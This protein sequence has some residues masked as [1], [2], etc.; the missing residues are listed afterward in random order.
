MQ[1]LKI[2]P[3]YTVEEVATIIQT[4]TNY[5]Y[6]LFKSNLLIPLKL[7]RFKVRHEELMLFLEKWQGYDLTDPF[8]I[9]N[10]KGD[11]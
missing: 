3:L 1:E 11:N 6:S 4:N 8:N 10:L 2:K 9:E 7:G 5:V